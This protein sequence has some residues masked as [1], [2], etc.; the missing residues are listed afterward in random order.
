MHLIN[1]HSIVRYVFTPGGTLVGTI[2]GLPAREFHAPVASPEAEY[3]AREAA[4]L[5]RRGE[6]PRGAA[7]AERVPGYCDDP[8]YLKALE[9][10][11]L[12]LLP[13]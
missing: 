7:V 5:I 4:R 11:A 12:A 1:K 10:E 9:P 3:E 13:S 2:L 8:A 6:W